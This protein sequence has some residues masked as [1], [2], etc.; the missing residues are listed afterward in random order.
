MG[1]LARAREMAA[2]ATQSLLLQDRIRAEQER[3]EQMQL[4]A[5]ANAHQARADRRAARAAVR[6]GGLFMNKLGP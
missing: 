6:E 5:R 4:V 3:R 1:A 2:G